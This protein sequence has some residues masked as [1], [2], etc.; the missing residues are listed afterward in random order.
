MR[1]LLTLLLLLATLSACAGQPTAPPATLPVVPTAVAATATFTA[2]APAA[3]TASATLSP[4]P[5]LT[6]TPTPTPTPVPPKILILSIDGLRPDALQQAQ[7]P[8]MLGLTQRG[9]FTFAAQTV[10]PSATLPAHASML[11]GQLPEVHGILWNDTEPARGAILVPT[12]FSL[13]H[14]RGLRTVMVVGKEKFEH[15]S[16]PGTIDQYVFITNGDQFVADQAVA[17]VAA[18][19][20]VM[21]V[22]FPNTD[23]FGHLNGWMSD[24]Q[25][26]Q[27][28]R[29]DDAV[30]R[31]LAVLPPET[32]VMLTADHGGHGVVHG[33]RLPEDMTI[34]WIISGP[35]VRSGHAIAGPVSIMD[36]AA[37]AAYLLG[38][39]LPTEAA[40]RPVLEAFAEVTPPEEGAVDLADLLD[41]R[42]T[43]GASQFPPRSEM[44]AAVVDGLIYV[45][46]GLGGEQAFQ[47]YDPAANTWSDLARLPSARHHLMAAAWG[48]QVYAFGGA[49]GSAW[50]PSATT[51][52]Y[53]PATDTWTE[54]AP[55]PEPR[56]SGAA[57]AL[58]DKLYVIGGVGVSTAL[59][60][61]DPA[62]DTWLTLAG[63]NEP[64]EHVAAA[65]LNGEIYALGGR[66]S[67][68]GELSSVE[69][70][71]PAA[72]AWRP[73][74]PLLRPRAGFSAD[75]LAGRIVIAGGEIIMTG[76][77]ALESMEVF[78]PA[79]QAWHPGPTLP[80][81]IHGNPVAAFDGRFFILGGSTVPG[82]A[83]N[84]G[85]AMVYTP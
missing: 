85:V 27:L 36:T 52:I 33:S 81:P 4:S 84:L 82:A 78:D 12:L 1:K 80:S 45:P 26:S 25:I 14:E 51:Y 56:H 5:T 83:A 60:E 59:L 75:V 32:V 35:G 66:W 30:G 37:T 23:Y 41:G 72:D 61:Y 71:D 69:I 63:L 73:G 34:P 20:D 42:W 62:A 77:E 28:G 68:T 65:G 13:A 40:G 29:T 10:H 6:H 70:Y 43:F 47:A 39:E 22:N 46:G 3:P 44:P 7:A 74:P 58:N 18:G 38:L 2:A 31:L 53:D 79:T 54:G 67:G 50:N 64:R 49:V 57:V 8:H 15:L 16:A 17:E 24:T 55:M 19:F 21:F 11:S 48:G 9:A 76:S